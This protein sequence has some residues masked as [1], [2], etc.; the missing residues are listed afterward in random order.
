[1]K[2]ATVS[3]RENYHAD[4]GVRLLRQGVYG[5]ALT[6]LQRQG[7]VLLKAVPEHG[8]AFR[9]NTHVRFVRQTRGPSGES[10]LLASL[11]RQRIVH[12]FLLC[13]AL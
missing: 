1:M 10:L 13:K 7:P 9:A 2:T 11:L 12:A 5:K 3:S 6:C 4:S 8:A